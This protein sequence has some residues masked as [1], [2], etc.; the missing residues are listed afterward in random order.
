MAAT[1]IAGVRLAGLGAGCRWGVAELSCGLLVVTGLIVVGS[2]SESQE[3][4]A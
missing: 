3:S 1:R 4:G 2:P